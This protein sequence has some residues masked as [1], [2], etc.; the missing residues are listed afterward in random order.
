[1]GIENLDKWLTTEPDK[2]EI[3]IKMERNIRGMN[4]ICDYC[5]KEAITASVLGREKDNSG[6]A[7]M[8]CEEHKK[9]VFEIYQ[10]EKERYADDARDR[11][12]NP[13]Y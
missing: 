12:E 4:T 6:V 9:M 3:E 1:M 8:L 13:F 5:E 11:R 7:L 2:E 10:K